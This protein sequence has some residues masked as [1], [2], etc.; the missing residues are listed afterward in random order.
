MLI[1]LRPDEADVQLGLIWHFHT[2]TSVGKALRGLH[3]QFEWNQS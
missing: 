3:T 2:V 1:L